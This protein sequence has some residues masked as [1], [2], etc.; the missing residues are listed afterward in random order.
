M[1]EVKVFGLLGEKLTHSYSKIIHEAIDGEYH[2]FEVS[3]ENFDDFLNRN[4]GYKK[5]MR[6]GYAD[7]GRTNETM[8]VGSDYSWLRLCSRDCVDG[9]GRSEICGRI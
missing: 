4:K 1:D 5:E 8:A 3:K 6:L 2:L 9:L 7:K